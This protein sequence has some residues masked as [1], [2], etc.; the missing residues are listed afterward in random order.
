MTSNKVYRLMDVNTGMFVG[1]S[2]RVDQANLVSGGRTWKSRTWI[3]RA[4]ET[5]RKARP[6]WRLVVREKAGTS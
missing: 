4:A 2:D 5:L 6:E 1:W 3:V